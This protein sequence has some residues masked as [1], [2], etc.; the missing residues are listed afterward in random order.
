MYVNDG[1]CIVKYWN[2]WACG[3]D[4]DWGNEMVDAMWCRPKGQG[5][6]LSG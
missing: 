1:R 2:K 3:V 5:K 4:F 6:W